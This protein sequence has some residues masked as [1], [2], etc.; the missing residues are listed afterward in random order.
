MQK[1]GEYCIHEFLED[2]AEGWISSE[3]V[4]TKEI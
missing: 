2:S 3:Q 4:I 1:L